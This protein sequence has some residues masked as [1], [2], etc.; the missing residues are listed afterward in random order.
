MKNLISENFV[1]ALI[2]LL[3][4][5]IIFMHKYKSSRD[6]FKIKTLDF[7]TVLFNDK[8]NLA[9][10]FAVEETFYRNIK[11]ILD[12]KTITLF[13]SLDNPTKALQLYKK[14]SNYLKVKDGKL[15]YK[16]IYTYS[17]IRILVKFLKPISNVFFYFI[18]GFISIFLTIIAYEKITFNDIF[19]NELVMP[20]MFF[21]D[22]MLY[23]LP[24]FLSL[25]H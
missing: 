14:S 11:I 8:D 12:Y 2:A 19:Q 10:K 25:L 3:P 22:F 23:P 5:L 16:K 6:T 18:F 21:L 13:L 7:L 15:A 17:F 4:A 24:F 1:L 9:H 20:D